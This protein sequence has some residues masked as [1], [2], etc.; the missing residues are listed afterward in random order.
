MS[1]YHEGGNGRQTAVGEAT[2]LRRRWVRIGGKWKGTGLRR[3]RKDWR[4]RVWRP[5]AVSW[6]RY[7]VETNEEK[8]EMERPRGAWGVKYFIRMLKV[9]AVSSTALTPKGSLSQTVRW[10]LRQ[11]MCHLPS[12]EAL[13]PAAIGGRV[14]TVHY[15]NKENEGL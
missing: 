9:C 3:S 5:C 11:R 14:L 6:V 4:C 7:T 1:G 10:R 13:K 12:A 2:F 15:P 8:K